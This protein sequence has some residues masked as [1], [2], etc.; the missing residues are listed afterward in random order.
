M[1]PRAEIAEYRQNRFAGVDVEADPHRAVMLL[2][3]GGIE[4]MR[5]ADAAIAAGRTDIKIAAINAALDI[6]DVLRASLNHDEG[7]QIAGGLEA[8]YTY[9][10]ERLVQ[11]NAGNDREHLAEC[12]RLLSDIASAWAEV[13]QRLA[14]AQPVP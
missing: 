11:A 1:S 10:G 4:R 2:L 14:S 9:I 6:L 8:L 12:I 5:Q 3:Q 13:P 7:G